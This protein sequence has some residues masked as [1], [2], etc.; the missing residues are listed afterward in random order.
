M[1]P[2]KYEVTQGAAYRPPLLDLKRVVALTDAA[3]ELFK[4]LYDMERMTRRAN[5]ARLKAEMNK[6][7]LFSPRLLHYS[8]VEEYTPSGGEDR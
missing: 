5:K 4:I 3:Q 6:L 8:D 2:R 1:S 7:D